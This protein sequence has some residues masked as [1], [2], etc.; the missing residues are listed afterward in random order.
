LK[1]KLNLTVRR[2]SKMKF[3]LK[4][5]CHYLPTILKE[6]QVGIFYIDHSTIFKKTYLSGKK[7]IYFSELKQG[8]I[9]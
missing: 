7:K 5:N 2:P 9:P 1:G 3:M 6:I 4:S 8:F